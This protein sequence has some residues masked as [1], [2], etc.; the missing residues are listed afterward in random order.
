[1][2]GRIVLAALAMLLGFGQATAQHDSYKYDQFASMEFKQWDFGP[3]D[4]Y[5]SRYW[6]T[7]LDMPWPIPDIK[8]WIPTTGPNGPGWHDKGQWIP[9][10]GLYVDVIFNPY[11]AAVGHWDA[12]FNADGYV[13]QSWRQYFSHRTSAAAESILYKNLSNKQ[14]RYWGDIKK[15]DVVTIA[16]RTGVLSGVT[17]ATQITGTERQESMD[18]VNKAYDIIGE[19]PLRD[20]LMDRYYM[21]QEQVAVIENAHMDN[22]RK[23]VAMEEIN[24][25]YKELAKTASVLALQYLYR[26]DIQST[27]GAATKDSDWL[28]KLLQELNVN[29]AVRDLLR[30]INIDKL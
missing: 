11:A 17:G 19:G 13:N 27:V 5:Y 28:D 1:M 20:D 9:F 4:F 16:D 22:A 7:I 10:T 15:L 21:L 8:G 2:N 18:A 14:D 24:K 30:S 29:S 23:I 25:E 3:T 12:V 6:G 26:K